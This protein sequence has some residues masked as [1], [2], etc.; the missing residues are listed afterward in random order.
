MTDIIHHI[1][2]EFNVWFTDRKLPINL[3]I[4]DGN[5]LEI[6]TYGDSNLNEQFR[7]DTSY[8]LSI[9]DPILENISSLIIRPNDILNWNIPDTLPKLPDGIKTHA[10]FVRRIMFTGQEMFLVVRS[11]TGP[12]I[13]I[14]KDSLNNLVERISALFFHTKYVEI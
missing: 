10:F 11:P 2:K 5:G 12:L 3:G 4:F 9:L 14:I 6:A 1:I 8:L 13:E 7:G